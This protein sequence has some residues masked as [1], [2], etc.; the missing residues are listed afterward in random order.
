V[1][2][3]ENHTQDPALTGILADLL[4][5]G[6]SSSP[7]I[8]ILSKERMR[9]LQN[10]LG[11]EAMNDSTGLLLAR[12]AQ[13]QTMVSTK[14]LQIGKTYRIN[15]NIYDVDTKDLLLA[16]QVQGEGQDAIFDMI[17]DLSNKIKSGLEVIP[18]PGEMPKLKLSDLTTN[19][20]AA[21]KL[22]KKAHSLYSKG[23]VKAIP[24]LEQA[25]IIDS[26][27]VDALR[28]LAIAYDVIGDSEKALTTAQRAKELSRERGRREYLKSVIVETRIQRNW[29][30]A[31][32]YLKRYL[33]LEPHDIS[34]RTQLGYIYS[35]YKK[36]FDLAIEQFNKAISIDSKNLS[37]QLGPAYNFLGHAYL[38]CAEYDQAIDA[39]TKYRE[40]SPN[41]PD[42]LHSMADALFFMGEYEK[43]IELYH[44]VIREFS[45]FYYAYEDLGTA[46]LETGKW[47]Q[48]VSAFT[49]YLGA[50]P[51]GLMHKGHVLLARVYYTQGYLDRANDELD[52]A[53]SFDPAC[54][55]AH[56]LRGLIALDSG[57]DIVRARA[58]LDYMHELESRNDK[59]NDTACYHHLR[60]RILIAEKQYTTG[61][62][63][64]KRAAEVSERE[65]IYYRGKVASGYLESDL[66]DEAIV[67]ASEILTYNKNNVEAL[68]ILGLANAERGSR[69]EALEYFTRA[70]DVLKNADSDFKPLNELISKIIETEES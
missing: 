46:C 2:D 49:R 39:L 55:E 42:P 27:F 1:L 12:R 18:R 65:F 28:T 35:R 30:Q 33:V 25:V 21:Y 9:D 3:F 4:I 32:E 6:L 38:Y 45:D 20:L 31:I 67:E 68:Y 70:R 52:E 14:I 41:A 60:G 51:L 19:S 22:Y 5:T 59:S 57:C 26:T 54:I 40:I 37:G 16:D 61:L 7:Y 44:T 62:A 69:D 13:I 56:W 36:E 50:V 48:A 64:L 34:S 15:T 11:I 24:Y 66:I 63:S 10:D 29:D 47:R 58:E 53:L 43:A 8:K 23:P 17:D